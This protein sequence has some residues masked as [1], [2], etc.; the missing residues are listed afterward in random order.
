MLVRIIVF[1]AIVA[2]AYWYWSGPY[3]E[4]INPDYETVLKRNNE[5]MSQCMRTA[6][7]QTGTTG[8]G[9][10]PEQAERQCAQELN[11]YQHD[12]QWHSYDMTRPD[13]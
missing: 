10:G 6:A 2:A 3:Q 7:Y 9:P 1:V 11:V 8:N 13:Q 5:A 4:K 12:G